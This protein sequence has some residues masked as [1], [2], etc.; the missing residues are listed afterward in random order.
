MKVKEQDS[1]TT[2]VDN[3]KIVPGFV[4]S[5]LVKGIISAFSPSGLLEG[6][7]FVLV[8]S[9]CVVVKVPAEAASKLFAD[10][11][12]FDSTGFNFESRGTDVTKWDREE[13]HPL[14]GTITVANVK[15]VVTIEKTAEAYIPTYHKMEEI[16]DLSQIFTLKQGIPE[17]ENLFKANIHDTLGAVIKAKI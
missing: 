13:W 4:G 7:K 12:Y 15:Y 10:K 1:T 14:S 5:Q 9:D 17:V 8:E 2:L 16:R 6:T 3:Q 11:L